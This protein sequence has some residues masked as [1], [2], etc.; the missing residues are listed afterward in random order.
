MADVDGAPASQEALGTLGGS[1]GE[2]NG[3][4]RSNQDRGRAPEDT[5]GKSEKN[6]GLGASASH[7]YQNPVVKQTVEL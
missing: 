1:A 7:M 5:F 3:T 2:G 4:P 6:G